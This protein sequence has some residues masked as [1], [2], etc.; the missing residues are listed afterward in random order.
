MTHEFYTPNWLLNLNLNSALKI[1]KNEV[2]TLENFKKIEY[3][4]KVAHRQGGLRIKV[5]PEV[6]D[7]YN[8]EGIVITKSSFEKYGKIEND[9]LVFETSREFKPRVGQIKGK[10]YLMLDGKH[11]PTF[12]FFEADDVISLTSK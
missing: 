9:Y 8:D 5:K 6:L 10:T 4:I 12:A 1:W 7:K 3:P 11:E 2:N